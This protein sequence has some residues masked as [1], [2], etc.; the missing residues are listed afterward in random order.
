[1]VEEEEEMCLKSPDLDD[2]ENLAP[3][4]HY[5]MM[6]YAE[7]ESIKKKKRKFKPKQGQFGLEAGLKHLATE[8]KPL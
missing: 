5:I 4:A 7:N 3:V 6:H 1:M 8:G 2:E